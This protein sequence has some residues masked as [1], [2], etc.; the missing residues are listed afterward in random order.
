MTSKVVTIANV[1]SIFSWCNNVRFFLTFAEANVDF[2]AGLLLQVTTKLIWL[3]K[4]YWRKT[5]GK[6]FKGAQHPNRNWSFAHRYFPLKLNWK[7][8]YAATI[9]FDFNNSIFH[10]LK[11][12]LGLLFTLNLVSLPSHKITKCSSS[13]C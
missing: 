9:W 3:V 2:S 11:H 4:Q 5:R 12:R 10:T 7:W 8:F 13:I 1:I 6:A